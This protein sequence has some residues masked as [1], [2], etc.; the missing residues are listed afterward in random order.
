MPFEL[1]FPQPDLLDLL[2]EETMPWFMAYGFATALVL[3]VYLSGAGLL[4]LRRR[5]PVE[6]LLRKRAA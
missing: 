1:A 3:A 2:I 4:R 6:Q 5:S